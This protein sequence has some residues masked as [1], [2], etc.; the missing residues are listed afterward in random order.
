M[1]PL[2]V[3]FF[4]NNNSK[5]L[6]S[7]DLK[8]FLPSNNYLYCHITDDNHFLTPC[9]LK[10]TNNTS[11]FNGMF[12][13]NIKDFDTGLDIKAFDYYKAIKERFNFDRFF[14]FFVDEEAKKC[15][16]GEIDELQNEYGSYPKREEYIIYFH[17][18]TLKKLFDLTD[19][20]AD[21]LKSFTT[22]NEKYLK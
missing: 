13:I 7:I 18:D 14:L 11:N 2:T 20:E 15:Y 16:C 5:K 9:G 4:T 8:N 10:F 12:D 1:I 21:K 3:S 22:K 19:E 17:I 6:V